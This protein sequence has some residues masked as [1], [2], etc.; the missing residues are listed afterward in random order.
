MGIVSVLCADVDAESTCANKD[1][2]IE[3]LL[4]S[5]MWEPHFPA[6]GRGAHRDHIILVRSYSYLGIHACGGIRVMSMPS[7]SAM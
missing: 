5:N 7:L 1:S 3:S 2:Y 4:Y 6:S